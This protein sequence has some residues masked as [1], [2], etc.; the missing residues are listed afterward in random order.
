MGNGRW[1]W[2][3]VLSGVLA[4]FGRSGQAGG[5]DGETIELGSAT[6]VCRGDRAPQVEKTA[7][8]VLAEELSKRT[9]LDWP[10]ATK[11]S[12]AGTVVAVTSGRETTLLDRPVPAH[13]LQDVREGYGIASE[14][15]TSGQCVIWVVG[16]DPKGALNGV[17]RLLRT[18]RLKPGSASLVGPLNVLTAPQSAIRGHQLGY[19][20]TANSYDAWD[21]SMYEAYIRELA[22]FGAN[23]IENIPFQDQ[24]SPHMRVPRREMNRRLGEICQRYGMAYW[25][26]TPATCDLRDAE[27]RK[28]FLKKHDAFFADSTHLDAVFIPG[29][30]PGNNPPQLVLPLLKEMAALLAKHHPKAGVWLSLQNFEDEEVDYFFDWIE[31]RKPPWFTGVVGGPSSPLLSTLRARLPA[32]YL[33]RDY[34]DIT[35]TILSQ[36]PTPWLDPAFAFTSGREGTNPE[37]VRYRI[38]HRATAPYT[39]GFISYSDG[40]HDDVNKAVWNLLGWDADADLRQGM[41]EY[42]RFFFGPDVA[43][44]AADG[45]FALERNWSGPLATNGGV[46]ATHALWKGLDAKAPHLRG[47]W[48]WQLCQLKAHYDAYVRQRLLHESRYEDQANAALARAAAIGSDAA[49]DQALAALAQADQSCHPT[50]RK[51]VVELCDA[52]FHSIGFQTS[53]VKYGASGAQRGAVLDFLDHPLNNRWWLEDEFAKVR[54][55]PTEVEKVAR[56]DLLRMWEHPGPGSFYDDIG[57]VAKSSHVIRGEW[58][59]TDPTMRRNPNPDFMWWDGGRS[60]LRPSWIS[61]M[62]WPIGL[63]YEPIDPSA[64]YSVRTTGHGQCLLRVNG[65]RVEPIVDGR[66]VGQ[67]KEF[68]LPRKLYKQGRIELTFD[69]PREPGVNWRYTSRLNEVWLIRHR[70]SRREGFRAYTAP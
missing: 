69:V 14:R 12:E 56:I 28:E 45:I 70:P 24:E 40:I 66:D 15:T 8:V 53:V 11:W 49:I 59:N 20:T 4:G 7:V 18:L 42:C 5:E 29:G 3:V 47:N 52:L 25:V 35:H 1:L 30:D 17:G 55:L 36:Y 19:R 26:W 13:L 37:P 9:G 6:I 32:E 34:P 65:T 60:R 43:E 63:R 44:E 39:N 64:S 62:D 61:K 2:A 58:I 21:A 57:N 68:L 33:L 48:R 31:E 50:L 27:Q 41:V 23:A 16:A 10:T 46:A 38:I 51:Q 22:I 54:Q 67:I